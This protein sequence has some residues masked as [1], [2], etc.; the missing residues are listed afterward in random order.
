[1]LAR[2]QPLLTKNRRPEQS[3]FTAGRSTMDAILAL[4]LL[5]EIRRE[6]NRPLAVAYVDIKAAFDSVDRK[7]LWLALKGIGVP[8]P[9]MRLMQDLHVGSCARVRVGSQKSDSFTTRSGVRQGCVLAPSLF[10]R[11]MDWILQRMPP[12]CGIKVGQYSFTDD[13]YADDV[14]LM[15]HKESDLQTSL[16][17]FNRQQTP[18]V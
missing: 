4:R 18:L 16:Y 8:D 3:G 7:A 13:D 2:L 9:L 10:Y 12:I 14:A 5:S 17:H 6:F 15:G 1:M 11:A